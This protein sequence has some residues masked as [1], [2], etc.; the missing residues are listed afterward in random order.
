MKKV[1]SLLSF[2]TVLGFLGFSS[3]SGTIDVPGAEE[4]KGAYIVHV[5]AE[6]GSRKVRKVLNELAYHLP[7]DSYEID[8][9]Y[10]H[11]YSGFSL[12]A[13]KEAAAVIETLAGV[14]R[15]SQQAVYSLAD[16]GTPS[17]TADTS[18][19]SKEA[20]L[21]NYSVETMR[22]TAEEI[23]AAIPDADEA[24]LGQGILIG[25]ID[26]GLRLNQVE[27]TE[28]RNSISSTQ[29]LN[30][31]AFVPLSDT[32]NVALTEDEAKELI[33]GA[34]GHG[35][36]INSKIPYVRDYG[37]GDDDVNVTAPGTDE[38]GYPNYS[39]GTHVASLATANGTDFQ[40]VA[41]NA[42]LAMFKLGSD[43]NNGAL[44][45]DVVS[46]L[47]DAV[48]LGVDVVNLS[49]GVAIVETDDS[50]L[51]EAL[52]ECADAGVIVNYAAGNDGKSQYSS[53][54]AYSDWTRD[55]VNTSMLSREGLYDEKAN[56]VA[57]TNPE[58]AFYTSIMTVDGH[59]VSYDDQVV[60]RGTNIQF[61]EEHPLTE[62]LAGGENEF[63]FA[64][65]LGYGDDKDY[66]AWK[67]ATGHSD[68]T[69]YIAVVDR[70]T[71][72][73][74][75]KTNAAMNAGAE[76][77]IVINNE[78]SV[79]FNMTFDFG[80]LENPTIPVVFVFQ[81]MR[82]YFTEYDEHGEEVVGHTGT[83]NLYTDTAIAAPDGNV[84]ASYSS[85]GVPYD[86]DISPTI[87]APGTQVIGA[88]SA[89]TQ[90]YYS[91]LYGYDNMQG[92][93]MATPN[94]TGA[95]ASVLSQYVPGN[96][97]SAAV[98]DET[99]FD[100]IKA[101]ISKIAM[102]TAD[103]VNDPTGET[104][105][106]VKLQG[107][108]RVNV[109]D[110]LEA[111]SYVTVADP[112]EEGRV[113]SKIE[114]K[115]N[116][117]LNTELSQDKEAYIEFEYTVHNDS[118]EQR[119]YAPDITFLIPMLRVQMTQTEYDES[120]ENQQDVPENM[121]NEQTVSVNDDE[122][123]LDQAHLDQLGTSF[124][125]GAHSTATN[126]VRLRIDDI[127]IDKDFVETAEGEEPEV[128]SFHGTLREYYDHFYNQAGQA[129]GGLIEGYFELKEIGGDA[130]KDLNVPYLGF[131]G[132]Y[133]KGEAVEPFSF[134][135]EEGRL[136]NSE[137]VDSYMH[138]L[139]TPKANAYSGS[140]LTAM[141]SRTTTATIL[142][143]INNFN[144]SAIPS[145]NAG[146]YR[147]NDEDDP[148]HLYAGA[149][150]KTD[151]LLAVFFVNRAVSSA[152]WSITPNAGTTGTPM[153]GD[154][155]DT[156]AYNPSY[157]ELTRSV[158][159]PNSNDTTGVNL[160]TIHHGWA[161]MNLT[162]LEEGDYTLTFTFNYKG[163]S[164]QQ[165][166]TY[167]L[168]IDRTAPTLLSAEI[169][170]NNGVRSLRVRAKGSDLY[171]Q[172]ASMPGA[173]T[174]VEGME[175]VYE[176]SFVL[177]D[178]DFQNGS[179]FLRLVDQANNT[180]NVI[181]NLNDLDVIASGTFLENGMSFYLNA[182][183]TSQGRYV[184]SLGLMDSYFE[185][186]TFDDPQELVLLVYIG[187]GKDVTGYSATY[188]NS[189]AESSPVELSYDSES[190]FLTMTIRDFD[191]PSTLVTNFSM[192]GGSTDNPG[193]GDSSSS[194]NS[195]SSSTPTDPETPETPEGGLEP[196]AIGLIV[197]GGV[198]VLA[199]IGVGVYFLFFKPKK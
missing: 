93:S 3:Q 126:S 130:R 193:T 170:N 183:N 102:S 63:Q 85:D 122:I 64:R 37:D 184:Y 120:P 75:E 127:Q 46:A 168:T 62:L 71:T 32:T 104:Y 36:Y 157:N 10:D 171:I 123:T 149:T 28:A 100:E 101:K 41:P 14:D 197:A 188:E 165:I 178:L 199:G 109:A 88:I 143:N 49:M 43:A 8:D 137:M 186:I 12:H 1:F 142:A 48:E 20:I 59:A 77:L 87:A 110:M 97:N 25:V 91:G 50:E 57:S 174:P 145:D 68:L 154:I 35:T 118:D 180:T 140:T 5:N 192:T 158:I 67:Q 160:Y 17:T 78:P 98:A 134:E 182:T 92:T 6:P 81:T 139:N 161:E 194:S 99:A 128:E 117:T 24:K 4:E 115:N 141:S 84:I 52:D 56:I 30:A 150:D 169:V 132:D 65:I 185:D 187:T 47:D 86:L 90:G 166:K 133:T 22:A 26:D 27:G 66:D 181:L 16:S 23:E 13:T 138:G 190:G 164:K 72:Q 38:M 82:D 144:G 172:N 34:V 131:Y 129:G 191:G 31:P 11:V 108:G 155:V 69:G 95:L 167:T 148:T 114:L 18:A 21:A 39:H 152:N 94:F 89:D 76:A 147:V 151:K 51:S 2:A 146:I 54:E 42:Q 83:L 105:A 135:K 29:G 196:W 73:F 55:T 119:T 103:P 176:T 136:Y 125:V 111:N 112:D 7:A 124:T 53:G 195:S 156:T 79:T 113:D 9:V 45:G 175:D 15:I 153:T 70:G 173:L 19:D 121:I 74:A 179:Y 61:D 80:A 60:D 107:A 163:L 96:A 58:T 162:S 44:L 189:L 159:Y 33:A 116:G 40:G 198:V 177:S 106:A